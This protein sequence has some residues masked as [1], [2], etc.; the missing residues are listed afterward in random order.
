MVERHACRAVTA[1]GAA[2][3]AVAAMSVG[4]ALVCAVRC[5]PSASAALPGP[6]SGVPAP[7]VSSRSA[8]ADDAVA[9]ASVVLSPPSGAAPSA[10]PRLSAVDAA[11]ALPVAS[12]PRRGIVGEDEREQPSPSSSRRRMRSLSESDFSSPRETRRR[13][14]PTIWESRQAALPPQRNQ[15]PPVTR[16]STEDLERELEIRN[17][18]RAARQG[19]SAES[20]EQTQPQPEPEPETETET[21]PREPEREPVFTLEFLEP[22]VDGELQ[23]PN[24]DEQKEHA[25]E[26]AFA[27][28]RFARDIDDVSEV[29]ITR[30][31]SHGTSAEVS[32][33]RWRG[34]DCAVKK[35]FNTDGGSNLASTQEA[36]RTEV[37]LMRELQHEN[38]VRFYGARCHPPD[39]WIVMELMRSERA[40]TALPAVATSC[41]L[42]VPH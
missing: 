40:Y 10:A 8:A 16:Q 28:F 24:S 31:L 9:P 12:L 42:M 35:Y 37:F 18:A 5:R 13:L 36:F 38:I 29:K 4:A 41:I 6:R 3:G 2:A 27:G 7:A 20:P 23:R 30:R 25:D 34:M 26:Q 1:F 15:H 32:A 33:A 19:T 21:E 22:E 39:L 14:E 17:R 11:V